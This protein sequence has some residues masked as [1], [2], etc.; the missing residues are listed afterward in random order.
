MKTIASIDLVPATQRAYATNGGGVVAA[1]LQTVVNL[2]DG[3]QMTLNT[4]I[5]GSVP[6]GGG[7]LEYH[8]SLPRGVNVSN[9]DEWLDEHKTAFEADPLW[10]SL[11]TRADAV[12]RTFRAKANKA[13]ATAET[14]DSKPAATLVKPAK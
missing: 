7:S 14:A 4:A 1:E 12:Y 9:R 13:Q 2:A 11:K 10:P 3:S 6:R 5:F 8:A